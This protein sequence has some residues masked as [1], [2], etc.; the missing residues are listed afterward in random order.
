MMAEAE[1]NDTSSPERQDQTKI[2]K[3]KHHDSKENVE[4]TDN[5][6]NNNGAN[7]DETVEE[8]SVVVTGKNV[9]DAKF[10]TVKNFSDSGLPENVLQCYKRFE[11][12]FSIQSRAVFLIGL[13]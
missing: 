5:D 9:G 7:R 1:D 3:K 12:P 2:N 8:G 4:E 6:R 11:K 13:S 10:A